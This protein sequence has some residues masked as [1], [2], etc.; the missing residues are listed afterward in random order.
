MRDLAI[1]ALRGAGHE[2]VLSDLYAMGFNAQGGPH[3]FMELQDTT[4]FKYQR[5]QRHAVATQTF[6]SDVAG[7]IAKVIRADLLILQFPLWWYSVPA[8]LKGWIDRVFAMGFAYDVGRL[9][10]TG[11]LRGK[12][13]MLAVTTGAA[14]AAFGAGAVN[15]AMDE[16]L[17]HIHYGVFR[18]AGVEV[19]PPFVAH[20][21][22]RIDNVQRSALLERYGEHLLLLETLEPLD[23]SRSIPSEQGIG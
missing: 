19:L 1:D 3:D 2:V 13:A 11:P 4:L 21:V 17:W 7:E 20:G 10:E 6:A 23:L 14:G 16:I 18:V 5:E 15:P 9:H 8:I 22:A 12:R